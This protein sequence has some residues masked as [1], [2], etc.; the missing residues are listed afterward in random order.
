[1]Y[2]E[3]AGLAV[4]RIAGYEDSNELIAD[5]RYSREVD[6]SPLLINVQKG[7]GVTV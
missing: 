4:P 3:L 5:A 2:R 7:E 1:M 6:R